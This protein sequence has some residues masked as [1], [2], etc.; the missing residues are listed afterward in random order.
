MTTQTAEAPAPPGGHVFEDIADAMPH[1][2]WLAE[3]TGATTYHNRRI[4]EYAGLPPGATLG[5]RWE[6]MVHPE[7]VPA[8]RVAWGR[9][10]ETGEPFEIEYRLRRGDGEYRW[11]HARAAAQRDGS[12]RLARWVGTCTDVEDQKR[13]AARMRAVV[14]SMADG[15]VVADPSGHLLEW[16]PAALRMHGYADLD[17]ARRHLTAFVETFTLSRPGGGPLAYHDWPMPRILRGE[18]VADEKLVLRRRDT[19]LELVVV[20]SGAPVRGPGGDIELGVLTIHDVTRRKRAEGEA[21]RT[22]ELLRAVADSTTDAVFVKDPEGKY[23]LCNP[24]TAAF[25]GRPAEDVLGRTDAE[26]FEPEGARLV[27][28]R[29]RLVIESGRPQ[30]DEETLTLAGVTRTFLATKAPYRDGH[31]TVIGVVGISRDVTDRNRLAAERDSLLARLQIH[32]ERMPLV[33]VLFDAGFRVTDWNPAAERVFGYPKA[34]ALGKGPGDLIAPSFRNGADAILARIRAGDMAA[35]SVNENLTKDGRVV[36][37]EWFN[38][39]LVA[40]D[41]KFVGLLCLAQDVTQ[42][43]VLEEQF[44]QAQKMEAVGQL[45][46]GVAHDFNNLLTIINGYSDLLLG[47]L[48]PGDPSRELL[49]E[50]HKAG[51]RSAG[52]TRQLLAFS[53]KQVLATW[54]LDLNAV[55]ADTTSLLRRVIGEDVR[56][57]TAPGRGLW[58]VRADAGQVE[59]VL[60][61]LAVNARDAMPRGGKLTIETANV[62]LD[63]GYASSHSDARPGSHVLLAVADTGHGMTPEVRAK[64]FE[65]FFTTKEVGKGTGLGLATVYGIVKQSGGHIGVNS[66]VGVGTTFKVYLPR[67]EPEGGAV[68]DPSRRPTP[69]RGSE[70]IL[71]VEDEPAVRALTRHVLRQAGYAVLEAAD[72][73]TALRVAAGHAG[74][75]HLLVTDVVMPGFGGREVAE[76]LAGRHP[77]M[78][79]LFVSGYTDDAVVRHGVLYDRVNFL[80]KPFTPIALAQK[81]REVLDAPGT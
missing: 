64:I 19:G 54:I 41:G 14:E 10:L 4:L 20:Y 50:I 25:L 55:V 67:V 30:T 57:S 12:G 76:Q 31:G 72:G 79:V 62:E 18:T 22:T 17:E 46:G 34:E 59:Q 58:P 37:C 24:A 80:Q 42:R 52:L 53:R 6:A 2:V 63:E 60:L 40:D 38:T 23:L 73:D 66:E 81:V 33:Y 44:R 35:H 7:D 11:F 3:S 39:P 51:E 1:M 29:D 74:P 16:N 13:A 45:A 77:G 15:L 9:S 26:L 28:A 69:P 78:R 56:L 75:I 36:T 32:I 71:V 70:T 27:M 68:N 5:F 49:A 8:T 21:R 65:P 48:P 61:N 47:S 43:R